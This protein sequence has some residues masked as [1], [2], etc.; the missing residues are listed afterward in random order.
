LGDNAIDMKWC[1]LPP[2][3]ATEFTRMIA[4]PIAVPSSAAI[5]GPATSAVSS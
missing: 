3:C 1:G 2:A 5:L 4:A